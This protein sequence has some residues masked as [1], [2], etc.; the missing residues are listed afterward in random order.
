MRGLCKLDAVVIAHALS[1]QRGDEASGVGSSANVEA[2][3]EG[4]GRCQVGQ[5]CVP[6]CPILAHL[7]HVVHVPQVAGVDPQ[8]LA[9]QEV[10]VK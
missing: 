9:R 8:S 7:E 5:K 6:A 3:R 10:D 1:G 2:E 4:L